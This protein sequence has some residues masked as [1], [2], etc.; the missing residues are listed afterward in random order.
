VE[1]HEQQARSESAAERARILQVG[2]E[3]TWREVVQEALAEHD[4]DIATDRRQ[5]TALLRT[6]RTYDLAVVDL[7]PTTGELLE[8]LWTHYPD[9]RRVVVA[10]VPPRQ[11]DRRGRA[12]L[13]ARY[14]VEEVLTRS[15]ISAPDLRRIVGTALE[16]EAAV[17]TRI[18]RA[19][20]R[21]RYQEWRSRRRAELEARLR[22]A[23]IVAGGTA[24]DALAV[25]ERFTTD[26]Y[27]AGIRIERAVTVPEILDA[28][29]AL[30]RIEEFFPE[31]GG[32]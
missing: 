9:T 19:E 25:Y 13:F 24:E 29:D 30:A 11:A 12:G 20:L 7:H 21:R 22:T 32:Q 1:P 15:T 5:A 28:A 3:P 10:E 18:R 14:G 23:E 8:L 26:A 16:D 17:E 6:G 27:D 4:L 31:A 2:D